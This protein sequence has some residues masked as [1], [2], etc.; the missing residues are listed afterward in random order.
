MAIVKVAISNQSSLLKDPELQKAIPAMQTQVRRDFAPVWGIDADL[1]FVSSGAPAPS[2]SWELIMFD[3]SDQAS[4]LGYHDLTPEGLPLGKVFART[5]AKY[6]SAWTVTASH[7]LLEMLADPD[8]NLSA[9]LETG[10]NSGLFY[11]YEVCDPCELDQQGYQIDGILL[12]DFVY[13][14]WFEGFRAQGSTRFDHQNLID[15]PF[16][17]L[18]GGY[19]GIFEIP[20]GLGWYQIQEPTQD[21]TKAGTI[22][23]PV[24][25]RRERRMTPRQSWRRSGAQKND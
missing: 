20:S 5:D 11:S 12:S 4:D 17:L 14:S 10:N 24:G 1:I 23:P 21:Q 8:I 22:R 19:A 6:S 25:S 7:E 16:K 15:Q 3:D 2:G 9:F 18:P 13:P